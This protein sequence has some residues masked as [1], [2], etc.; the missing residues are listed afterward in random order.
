MSDYVPN[1]GSSTKKAR[2][3]YEEG[4]KVYLMYGSDGNEMFYIEEVLEKGYTLRR[5][6]EKGEG[7]VKH[8]VYAETEL[9]LKPH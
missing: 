7:V 9:C 6:K 5:V 2:K 1:A 8:Q 3:T 4:T